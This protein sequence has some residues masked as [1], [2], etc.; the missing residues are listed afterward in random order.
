[1]IELDETPSKRP[2]TLA[3]PNT[4]LLDELI[5]ADVATFEDRYAL[6]VER[7]HVIAI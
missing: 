2:P 4:S 7:G 5:V 3:V 1:M 6:E